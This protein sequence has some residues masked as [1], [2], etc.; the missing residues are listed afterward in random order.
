[1]SHSLTSPGWISPFH[2]FYL[3]SVKERPAITNLW[4]GDL[5][6]SKKMGKGDSKRQK[7]SLRPR[8]IAVP[9]GV[10][11]KLFF[12]GRRFSCILVCCC[13]YSKNIVWAKF[14][15]RKN[16][17][18][19]LSLCF[20]FQ[21]PQGSKRQ[22][23]GNAEIKVINRKRWAAPREKWAGSQW[24]H[25]LWNRLPTLG[26]SDTGTRPSNRC[27][28]TFSWRCLISDVSAIGKHSPLLGSCFF[29]CRHFLSRLHSGW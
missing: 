13:I 11:H 22:N 6:N 27:F 7:K 15:L 29:F 18:S 2:P 21:K 12:G 23:H 28:N 14:W 1:M 20:L 4:F 19:V 17:R 8:W 5:P 9:P 16:W 26:E 10:P 3:V 24:R 25:H